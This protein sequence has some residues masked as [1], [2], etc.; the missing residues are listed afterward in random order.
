MEDWNCKFT[1]TV[2]NKTININVNNN[3]SKLW[4][5][6]KNKNNS[7]T[8]SKTIGKIL[9]E[10]NTLNV[11]DNFAL[12][13]KVLRIKW[14]IPYAENAKIGCRNIEYK[15]FIVE[16]E[17]PSEF[18]FELS[19]ENINPKIKG[20]IEVKIAIIQA[21]KNENF[22]LVLRISFSALSLKK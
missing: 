16:S 21:E 6:I 22:Q 18:S 13:P 8:P 10:F 17:S 4:F 9:R 7:R 19:I 14:A 20:R 15:K 12:P 5:G 2:Q 11:L 3:N 1:K